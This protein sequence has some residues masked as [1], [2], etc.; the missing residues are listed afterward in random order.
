M[1]HE[2]PTFSPLYRQIKNLI[3]QALD[4]GE[5]LPGQTI[6]SEQELALRFGVSQGTVRKAV[7]ELAAEVAGAS[8]EQTQGITQ[9][10]TAVGQ[11]DRT[12]QANAA[13]AEE[14]AA[15]AEEMNHQAASLKNSVSELV[16]LVGAADEA[17]AVRPAG[18][19]AGNPRS[20]AATP[21]SPKAARRS[22]SL[23]GM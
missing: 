12:T 10:N 18:P 11:M 5:W 14:C 13:S 21:L 16:H 19:G 3:V 4:A 9:I 20:A 8:R 6:P 22:G 17:V 2:S 7:D 23:V 1:A 15:A